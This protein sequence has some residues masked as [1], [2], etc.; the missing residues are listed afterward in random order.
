M[1]KKHG[2]LPGSF[3]SAATNVSLLHYAILYCLLE[4]DLITWGTV[5]YIH[6]QKYFTLPRE[7][8]KLIVL[9]N[10]CKTITMSYLFNICNDLRD[11]A[12]WDR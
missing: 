4:H 10:I 7:K 2:E 3:N 1:E 12:G 9:V 8:I 6:A 11:R 5:S